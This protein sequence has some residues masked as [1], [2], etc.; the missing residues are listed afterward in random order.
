MAR[1]RAWELVEAREPASLEKSLG[2]EVPP[3]LSEEAASV[4]RLLASPCFFRFLCSF[5]PLFG[6][7]EQRSG[8][9]GVG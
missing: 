2:L 6:A 3:K 4:V 8:V 1:A 5:A 7:K 9:W